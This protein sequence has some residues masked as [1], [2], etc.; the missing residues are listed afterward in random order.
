MSMILRY[1]KNMLNSFGTS[2]HQQELVRF[3]GILMK[4]LTDSRSRERLC[5]CLSNWSRHCWLRH[6]WSSMREH[7]GVNGH[8][9]G[10]LE[11]R[12]HRLVDWF[13]M[14]R[15]VHSGRLMMHRLMYCLMNG[16]IMIN[17]LLHWSHWLSNWRDRDW[18]RLRHRLAHWL[19]EL[20]LEMLLRLKILCM[21]ILFR[22]DRLRQRWGDWH[23]H[24]VSH[25]YS[26]WDNVSRN[27]N[28]ITGDWYFTDDWYRD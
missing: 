16:R 18:N 28:H 26:Y 4:A 11:D 6:G 3:W 21:K 25:W 5:E 15:L 8:L 9:R 27:W 22:S 7:I 1:V 24:I 2:L 14:Y 23:C 13:V 12:G 20:L 17:L 10:I 19:P